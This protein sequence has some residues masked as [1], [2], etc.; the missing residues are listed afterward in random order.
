MSSTDKSSKSGKSKKSFGKSKKSSSKS[1]EIDLL[2]FLKNEVTELRDAIKNI[3]G[4]QA[5]TGELVALTHQKVADLHCKIDEGACTVHLVKSTGKKKNVSKSLSSRKNKMNIMTYFKSK[6]R[7]TPEIFDEIITKEDLSDL[8]K[9]HSD[10]LKT[11]KKN[12]IES[13]K[14]TLIYKALIK[15]N[16]ENI[17]FVRDMKEKEENSNIEDEIVN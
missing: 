12:N 8:F 9:K 2:N 3:E 7:N 4:I 5:R 16:K 14:L 15:G 17:K 1:T 10:V 6:Y 13:Y 11:K